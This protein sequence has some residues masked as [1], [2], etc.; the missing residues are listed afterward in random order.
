MNWPL[1][2]EINEAIQ[3]PAV[4]FND[5]EL[6]ASQAAVGSHGVP[7]PHSGNFGDVYRLQH[8][9]G[10][11][12]AVKCFTRPV[13]GIG[14]RY[15]AVSRALERARLPFTVGFQFLSQGIRIRGQWW[16]IVKMDWVEGLMLNQVVR[17]QAGNPRILDALGQI[18]TRLCGKLRDAGLAHGDL[19]HGN[20]LLVPSSGRSA[21]GLRLIDYDGMY[22]PAL[23]HSPSG[24]SGHENYQHPDRVARQAYSP[25]LDRFPHL[26]IATA[27]KALAVL[28]PS[29]WARYDTGENL[30]FTRSDFRNPAG[31]QLL[32]EL[33]AASHPALQPLVGQLLLALARPLP[34]TPWLDRIAPE[35]TAI[36]LTFE[37]YR[38]ASAVLGL[39]PAAAPMAP[40]VFAPPAYYAPP[41]VAIPQVE[42]PAPEYLHAPAP[43]PANDH[44]EF[45]VDE[46]NRSRYRKPRKQ[47]VSTPFLVFLGA[48]VL[49]GI[50]VGG[51]LLFK[52]LNE[53]KPPPPVV[54]PNPPTEPDD[55]PPLPRLAVQ[56]EKQVPNGVRQLRFSAKGDRIALIS[57]RGR[58]TWTLDSKTANLSPGYREHE[59]PPVGV[60]ALPDGIFASLV[61]DQAFAVV[62]QPGSEKPMAR[63]LCPAIPPAR[64]EPVFDASPDGKHILVGRMQGAPG[65]DAPH[66]HVVDIDAVQSLFKFPMPSG[67]IRFTS[68]G[69]QVVAAEDRTG[70]MRVYETATG[71][72]VS[73]AIVAAE[74]AVALSPDGKFAVYLGKADLPSG[75]GYHVFEV[76]SG[77]RVGTLPIPNAT[78]RRSVF[79]PDGKWLCLLTTAPG[80]R[81]TQ[82]F[83]VQT[84]TWM[85]VAVGVCKTG[86]RTGRASK[87]QFSP[88]SHLLVVPTD[89]SHL[90]AFEITVP[91]K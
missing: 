31:S 18:W 58:E 10:P 39:A 62:W 23:A 4:A 81:T 86:D 29:L 7:L 66:I 33:W 27:F 44:H 49:L 36:P 45:G 30:L 22:V 77:R 67:I 46:H 13:I 40:L 73:E 61:E 63:I 68:D 9:Q 79:S 90:V 17:E 32:H 84:E 54:E 41:P 1:P 14:D 11:R 59:G 83:L 25:D 2:H 15:A 56:W 71:R 87:P 24:E 69:A 5:P 35:G 57:H 76:E 34:Q 48:F 20:V 28:G 37:E 65:R 19:Q 43:F 74:Q 12:W 52:K 85:P 3:N 42:V 64:T 60:A 38:A 51:I 50:C 70:Q 89:G 82:A 47:S 6:A 55:R 16:P 88:D 21:F 80:G 26:A 8:P 53:P 75:Q 72:I 91:P 78:Q